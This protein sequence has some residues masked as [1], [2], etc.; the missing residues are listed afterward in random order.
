MTTDD[1]YPD[2]HDDLI[3]S[4]CALSARSHIALI[5]WLV[6]DGTHLFGLIH[7]QQTLPSSISM[8]AGKGGMYGHGGVRP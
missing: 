1:G 2:P 7:A 8:T 5:Q 4:I 6:C 3:T